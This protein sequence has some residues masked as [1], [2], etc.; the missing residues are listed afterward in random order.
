MKADIVSAFA[1]IFG[2]DIAVAKLRACKVEWGQE[3]RQNNALDTLTVHKMGWKTPEAEQVSLRSHSTQGMAEA[4]KYL[5]V[6]FDYANTDHSSHRELVCLLQDKLRLLHT[7]TCDKELKLEAIIYSLYPKIRYPAKLAGWSLE[8]YQYIDRI[9][10]AAFRRILQ[11]APTFPHALL[12]SARTE[13]GIGLPLFSSQAQ[14]DKLAMMFRAMHSDSSTKASMVSMLERGLRATHSLPT[15]IQQRLQPQDIKRQQR[16]EEFRKQATQQSLWTQS[17]SEWLA[18]DGRSLYRHGPPSTDSPYETILQYYNNRQL[19]DL[20]S[21]IARHLAESGVHTIT[22]LVYFHQTSQTFHWNRDIFHDIPRLSPLL[23]TP[24]P[25]YQV[26]P[27]LP[28]QCWATDNPIYPAQEGYIWEYIGQMAFTEN[29]N[30]RIWKTSTPGSYIARQR[31][32]SRSGGTD[33]ICPLSTLL[34][35][36]AQTIVLGGDAV[37]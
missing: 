24:A 11:L 19:P 16:D 6:T 5:G 27:L 36:Q 18:L 13:G 30:I 25:Q 20:P 33:C 35:G 14:Q 29:A 23:H 10:S 21:N 32:P 37:D 31:S 28:G 12:Y 17:I 7:L 26:V 15:G 1:I 8:S 22:D 2:L 3:S 4:L 34:N 9:F